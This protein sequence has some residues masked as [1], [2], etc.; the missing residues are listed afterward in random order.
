[1]KEKLEAI[2]RTAEEAVKSALDEKQIEEIRVKYIGKKGELTGLLKQM[3]S[4][5]PE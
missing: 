5:A 2:R 3:G 4:L 1:M